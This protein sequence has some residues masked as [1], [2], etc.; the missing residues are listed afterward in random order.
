MIGFWLQ[1]IGHARFAV[2]KNV[3][4]PPIGTTISAHSVCFVDSVTLKLAVNKNRLQWKS[5]QKINKIFLSIIM[6]KWQ[7]WKIPH[8]NAHQWHDRVIKTKHSSCDWF[9]SKNFNSVVVLIFA[10]SILSSHALKF[11][12][13]RALNVDCHSLYFHYAISSCRCFH[14]NTNSS[15]YW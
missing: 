1:N 9:R 3:P 7:E 11:V 12:E 15:K 8:R 5:Q 14:R 4:S 10:L 2:S 13:Q 6:R